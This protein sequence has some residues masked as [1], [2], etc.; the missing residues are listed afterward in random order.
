MDS[1]LL[2]E[3]LSVF[4]DMSI[5]IENGQREM[6]E[7]RSLTHAYPVA[8]QLSLHVVSADR[9]TQGANTEGVVLG[10]NRIGMD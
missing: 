6:L 3:N 8:S 2:E 9:K 5:C 4:G 10:V 1:A 7:E